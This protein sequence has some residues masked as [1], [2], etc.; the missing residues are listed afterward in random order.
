M[1]LTHLLYLFRVYLEVLTYVV[2]RDSS[3]NYSHTLGVC[4]DFDGFTCIFS[5]QF[6]HSNELARCLMYT[7]SLTHLL[8]VEVANNKVRLSDCVDQR[9]IN[10]GILLVSCIG[11]VLGALDLHLL[12]QVSEHHNGRYVIIPYH[13]PE[14][15]KCVRQGTLC[16]N[17]LP[18]PVVTLEIKRRVRSYHC[19]ICSSYKLEH[20]II[21]SKS[22]SSAAE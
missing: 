5:P 3:N 11:P 17:I 14:I 6:E 7:I 15:S 10:A 13:P 22:V 18:G 1:E 2:T 19:M 20:I 4:Q 16:C 9:H 8:N 21:V 12:H